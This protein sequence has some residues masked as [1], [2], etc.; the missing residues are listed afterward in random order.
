MQ[1]FYRKISIIALTLGCLCLFSSELKGQNSGITGKH[2]LVKSD[3]FPLLPMFGRKGAQF[4][5]EGP[6]NRRMSLGLSYQRGHS[7]AEINSNEE[8]PFLGYE[9]RG[10][11]LALRTYT[12]RAFPAPYGSYVMFFMNM[13]RATLQ[14]EDE[15]QFRPSVGPTVTASGISTYQGRYAE[16]GIGIGRQKIYFSRLVIDVG[17]YFNRISIKK[18]E[19]SP[20]AAPYPTVKGPTLVPLTDLLY[21]GFIQEIQASSSIPTNL[22]PGYF[23]YGSA[24]LALR[25][26]IGIL[27]F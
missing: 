24:N 27:L 10:Y 3:L 18:G 1:Y 11:G 21:W 20:E 17:I 8:K 22:Q 15:F 12:N 26:S 9:L 25:F 5:V 23:D 4:E 6:I 19:D 2:V 14:L 7:L 13:G 16:T